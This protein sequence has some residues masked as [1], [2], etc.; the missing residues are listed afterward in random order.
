VRMRA[1]ACTVIIIIGSVRAVMITTYAGAYCASTEAVAACGRHTRVWQAHPPVHGPI[2][3]LE[4]RPPPGRSVREGKLAA[5][6]GRCARGRRTCELRLRLGRAEVRHAP[7]CG[8][9]NGSRSL[10]A[11]Q[12]LERRFCSSGSSSELV[13]T[14][15]IDGGTVS[16]TCIRVWAAVQP[17]GHH[18]LRSRR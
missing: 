9:S 12:T 18:L 15:G 6:N 5:R 3:S 1:G 2:G 13:R 17:L 11:Q 16:A 4:M 10:S 14:L 8:S 7:C